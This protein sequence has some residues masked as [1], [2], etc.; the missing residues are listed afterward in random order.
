MI[1]AGTITPLAAA[2]AD[3]E[4][5]V[6]GAGPI[7]LMLGCLL[8]ERGV[9]AVIVD[10]E[11]PKTAHSKATLIWP[12][13]LELLDFTGVAEE[14]VATG[15]RIDAVTFNSATEVL[16]RIDLNALGD[17][18]FNF[19]VS[20]HQASVEDIM[21]R[22]L[23][24]LG[25]RIV[26][27]DVGDIAPLRD[28]VR[29]TVTHGDLHRTIEASWVVGADGVRSTVRAAM[30]VGYE[31]YDV[32]AQ[33]VLA[34]A[35]VHGGPPKNRADYFFGPSGSLAIGPIGPDLYRVACSV[36]Q[37]DSAHPEDRQW[38]TE[39]IAARA[40]SL[41]VDVR[42]IAFSARFRA[43]VRHAEKYRVGRLLLAGDAAHRMTP[44][45]G[46]GMNTGFGD[47]ASLGWRLAAVVRGLLD[48]SALDDY[49]DERMSAARRIEERTSAQSSHVDDWGDAGSSA[50]DAHDSTAVNSTAVNSDTTTTAM[51]VP[52]M[53]TEE[54]A[55]FDVQERTEVNYRDITVGLGIPV[56]AQAP[57]VVA[58]PGP[59]WVAD[60]WT[61]RLEAIASRVPK[62]TNIIDAS[63]MG[64][65]RPLCVSGAAE[66]FAVIR[67]D[68]VV[69]RRCAY[70][71]VIDHL[72]TAGWR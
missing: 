4:V 72:R 43:Q 19:G 1:E 39:L 38:L 44:A 61:S 55:Q 53:S 63:R 62:G 71:E 29:A 45:S 3:A 35:I 46:Q 58:W 31:G 6:V 50:T 25:G 59:R 30:N 32:P 65:T 48:E 69:E 52:V 7:G 70:D 64:N 14:V 21:R 23:V 11:R 27:G 42:G 2:P 56:A 47:A 34:D 28:R 10:R 17:T 54:L 13:S 8:V 41:D 9:D 60:E 57:T 15:H 66:G 37:V 26:T 5:V 68:G 33:F 20:L 49:A 67:P 24:E 36:A 51:P 16:R 40:P 18:R 22:R 12:R